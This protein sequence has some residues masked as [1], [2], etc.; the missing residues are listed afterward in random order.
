MLV[1]VKMVI[2][3]FACRGGSDGQKNKQIKADI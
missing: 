3:F 1:T 2:V